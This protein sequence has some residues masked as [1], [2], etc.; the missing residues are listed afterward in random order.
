MLFDRGDMRVFVYRAA[1]D[2]RAGFE[3]LHEFCV[4]HMSAKMN[5][6]HVYIF[7]GKN[8][9]R[10]KILIYDGTGL[11]LVAKKIERKNFMSHAELLGRSEISMDELKLIF[12]GGV[13]RQPVFGA[14]ADKFD[15]KT[16]SESSMIENFITTQRERLALPAGVMNAQV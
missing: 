4:Q 1:I 3:R 2:M 7:F 12:H 6:G 11:V 10:L 16:I 14:D 5:E 13:I 9:C 8:K 15:Q